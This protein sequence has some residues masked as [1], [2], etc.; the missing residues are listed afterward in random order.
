MAV[1]IR[2]VVTGRGLDALLAVAVL[3]TAIAVSYND[4]RQH[5]RVAAAIE[6]LTVACHGKPGWIPLQ[7]LLFKRPAW[8]AMM[9]GKA[10]AIPCDVGADLPLVQVGTTWL[11]QEYFHRALGAWFQV[12]GPRVIGFTTFQ[13][14]MYGLSCLFA[15]L[16]FRSGL[17][18][19]I[20][21]AAAAAFLF[22]KSHLGMAAMPIEYSKT[23]WVLGVVLFC[24]GMVRH[25][26]SNKRL[27]WFALAAGMTGGIGI[28]FKPDVI[29]VLPLAVLTPLLFVRA[30]RPLARKLTAAAIVVGGIVLTGA[31]MIYRNFFATT[32]SLL[33]VQLLGGQD[34]ETE[35]LYAIRPLY[36]YGLI[37][38]DSHIT[39]LINSYGQRVMGKTAV[40]AFFSRDMQQ[41]GSSLLVSL[42]S[43]FPGD[44]VLRTIAGTIRV[45]QLNGLS[46]AFS[47]AGLFAI[48]SRSQ[49]EGWFATLAIVYLSAYVSLV[50]QHRHIFHLEVISWFLLGSLIAGAFGVAAMAW[51]S[52]MARAADGVTWRTY[53]MSMARAAVSI[54]VIAGG[55]WLVLT[56]ARAYQQRAVTTLVEGYRAVPLEPRA[57]NVAATAPGEVTVRPAGLSVNERPAADP[58]ALPPVAD[59][60]VLTFACR[61]PGTIAARMK[62]QA[63]LE[64]WSNWNRRFDVI[65]AGAGSESTMMLPVY[66]YAPA[67]VLDGLV[68]SDADASTLRS[69]ATMRAAA[70]PDVWL[71]LLIPGDWRDRS[72]FE[73]LRTPPAMPY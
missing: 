64:D 49:R 32:G 73:T 55:A 25:D 65:C 4:L 23:P 34:F 51:R 39:W 24:I 59:Y 44:L 61:Q 29:A 36:D 41:M 47:V 10:D 21:L 72:W 67:Y 57:V 62:Y 42:W 5:Y 40:A 48:F 22:S 60:L 17:P 15:F 43:T 7:S 71:N 20:A 19:V 38:N 54:A 58:A 68:M 35:A 27:Y 50:F 52:L 31:P 8:V 56:V 13:A 1:L 26:A 70:S 28:G 63:P 14:G 69:A 66:Q 3:V 2:R 18:R 12:V 37:Y 11:L 46:M 6:D 33:P 53:G 30:P 16:I 9:E 45:L